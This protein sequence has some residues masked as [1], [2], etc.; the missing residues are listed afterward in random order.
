MPAIGNRRH[1]RVASMRAKIY[2]LTRG[3]G[4]GDRGEAIR[5]CNPDLRF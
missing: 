4:L 3:L 5:C 2:V 1:I